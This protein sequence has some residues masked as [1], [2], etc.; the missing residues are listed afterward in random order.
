MA[1]KWAKCAQDLL[2]S[3][4]GAVGT[5]QQAEW[6]MIAQHC[7]MD[8]KKRVKRGEDKGLNGRNTLKMKPTMS[9]HRSCIGTNTEISWCAR[10]CPFFSCDFSITNISQLGLTM[11]KIVGNF[12]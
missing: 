9:C 4:E 10:A 11:E 5:W 7:M 3:G 8:S 2:F 6:V 1:P 12:H